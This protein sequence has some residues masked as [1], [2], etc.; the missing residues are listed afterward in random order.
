MAI[1]IIETPGS[2]SANSFVS[3]AEAT[4]YL[5]ARLN[6]S[7]W[8]SASTEDQKAALVEATRE[9]AFRAWIGRKASTT[10]A[11]PWPREW[12]LDPDAPVGGTYLDSTTIPQRLQDATCELALEFLRAGTT[13]LAGAIKDEGIQ[14]K[15]VDVL[16]TTYFAPHQRPKGLARYPRVLGLIAPLLEATQGGVPILRG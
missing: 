4:A 16:T 10:Q 15:T 8:T 12:A 13:D 14:T 11:L 5:E 3:V 6:S 7:A 2:A 1:T 9:L